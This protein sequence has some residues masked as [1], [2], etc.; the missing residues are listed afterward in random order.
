M[1][2]ARTEKLPVPVDVTK[3]RNLPL[4]EE[5]LAGATRLSVFFIGQAVY[6][7]PP[8]KEEEAKEGAAVKFFVRST[9]PEKQ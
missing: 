1:G 2:Y 6:L 9:V 4:K 5:N 3:S 8:E 7:S